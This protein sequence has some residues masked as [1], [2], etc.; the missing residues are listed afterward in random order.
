MGRFWNR[1]D[2]LC[3]PL[4][5]CQMWSIS[6][7]WQ[8]THRQRKDIDRQTDR[9]NI[10]AYSV[11]VHFDMRIN[12]YHAYHKTLKRITRTEIARRNI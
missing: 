1:Y 8:K 3:Q 12:V 4:T 7:K 6:G 10:Y 11:L 5:E 9:Q 2:V